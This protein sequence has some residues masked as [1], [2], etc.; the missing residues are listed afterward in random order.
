MWKKLF[1]LK[2]ITVEDA[3]RAAEI[4]KALRRQEAKEAWDRIYM[5]T[6]RF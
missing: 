1:A 3:R 6:G 4:E 2:F 5:Y